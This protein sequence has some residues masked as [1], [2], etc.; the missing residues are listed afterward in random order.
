MIIHLVEDSNIVDRIIN[1]FEEVLPQKNVYICFFSGTPKYVKKRA[2]ILFEGKDNSEIA[3]V[4]KG[5]IDE[6]IIH[7]L[8]QVKINFVEKYIDISVPI[9]WIIWGGDLYNNLLT[10]H[11][12]NIYYEPY[13]VGWRYF[14]FNFATNVFKFRLIENRIGLKTLQFV[15]SRIRRFVSNV[16]FNLFAMSFPQYVNGEQV[17]GFFY[18]PIDSIVGKD[19]IKPAIK[20]NSILIGNS[21]SFSNNHVYSF[22][23]LKKLEIGNKKVV[24]PLSYGGSDKYKKHVIQKG[25]KIWSDHFSPILDFMPLD[26]YNKL[27]AD[28]LICIYGNWRQEAMGNIL[29]VLGFGAKVF[30][31]EK[32]PLY[33][34]LINMGFVVFSLEKI[35]QEQIDLPLLPN[36]I[37]HNQDLI[38]K[39]FNK[40]ALNE[41]I[42]N[43]WG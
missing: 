39:T 14:L 13:Y 33:F 2:C 25:R 10:Y 22:K 15:K 6:V 24:V 18:Y 9:T 17:K 26:D 31:S 11:G 28:S 36:E 43:I 1:D 41:A 5:D 19:L 21:A 23:F 7:Y 40:K 27:L 35:S 3:R 29:T 32:N 38:L 16:D 4:L 8:S 37:K 30:L 20:R 42:I 12:Y 34:W